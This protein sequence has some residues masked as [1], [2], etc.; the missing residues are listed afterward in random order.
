[1]EIP[2]PVKDYLAKHPLFWT[3]I[4]GCIIGGTIIF[5]IMNKHIDVLNERL[6]FKED[7]IVEYRQRLHIVGP[8]EEE[9]YTLSNNELK[10]KLNKIV[11]EIKELVDK[12]PKILTSE[13]EFKRDLISE[14]EEQLNPPRG[15]GE[16]FTLKNPIRF[17]CFAFVEERIC[18]READKDVAIKALGTYYGTI[19]SRAVF[20]KDEILSRI[21]KKFHKKLEYTINVEDPGSAIIGVALYLEEMAQLLD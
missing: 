6:G 1:M 19:R 17:A 3:F 14:K 20:L 11:T 5:F 21:P 18:Y 2:Q 16:I 7:L 9:Y 10:T 13:I 15:R 12:Y 8:T 4:F